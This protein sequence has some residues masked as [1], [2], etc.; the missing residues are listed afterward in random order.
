MEA[1]IVKSVDATRLRNDQ[2]PNFGINL[3]TSLVINGRSEGRDTKWYS[4]EIRVASVAT[5]KCPRGS[6]FSG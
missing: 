1:F 6:Y 2:I 4:R 3:A 5:S